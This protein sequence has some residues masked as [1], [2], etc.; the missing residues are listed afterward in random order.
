MCKAFVWDLKPED[1][2]EVS[3]SLA[4][5]GRMGSMKVKCL[6]HGALWTLFV[7]KRTAL[8]VVEESALP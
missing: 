4:D 2:T 7:G 3:G 6:L 8:L 1:L 5:K